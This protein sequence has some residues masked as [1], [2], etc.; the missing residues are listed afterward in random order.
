MNI[1]SKTKID[2]YYKT[3][4]IR[5]I[6]EAIAKEYT[7]QEM[8]CPI[9]LS[10][11]QESVAVAVC[12]NLNKNDLVV[13]SHRAHAH[14]LSKGG[15]IK[16]M[17]SELYLKKTGCSKGRTG[18]MHL[19]DRNVGFVA[20]IPIVASN[21]PIAV[22]LAKSIKMKKE[23][24]IVVA[25]F[26]EAATEEGV[27]F[28]SINFAQLFKLPILFICENNGYSVYSSKDLRFPKLRDN[29]KIVNGFGVDTLKLD[30][31]KLEKN[32]KL[33]SE[34]SKKVRKN[35]PFYIELDTY[36]YLEHCGP[37]NDD[38][39]NY[40]SKKEILKWKRKDP[41]NIYKNQLLKENIINKDSIKM[42][43]EEIIKEINSAFKFAKNSDFPIY[44]KKRFM[45]L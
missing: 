37:N 21:I 39:L 16:K 36:R 29:C 4:R 17:I 44:D 10:I 14:Y 26:G 32:Y 18:S 19:N 33:I 42:F 22:G 12:S 24:K 9:H 43:E 15:S 8:R 40:R 23:N 2:L 7:K 20:S 38:R 11:G 3:L 5:L 25:F 31:S 41:I 27:F 45:E 1:N 35:N 13:S 28:E 30:G 6:E 34:V